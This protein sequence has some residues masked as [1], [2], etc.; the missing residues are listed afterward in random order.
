MIND[1]ATETPA[2]I[3][4]RRPRLAKNQSSH[5]EQAR[6]ADEVSLGNPNYQPT[7]GLPPNPGGGIESFSVD[8]EPKKVVIPIRDKFAAESELV[9]FTSI[10]GSLPEPVMRATRFSATPGHTTGKENWTL[11]THVQIETDEQFAEQV[12]DAI[13]HSHFTVRS[14]SSRSAAKADNCRV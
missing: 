6:D 4:I 2:Q 7:K 12:K 5:H 9:E 14:G 8:A 11:L 13:R 1:L 10:L 3:A